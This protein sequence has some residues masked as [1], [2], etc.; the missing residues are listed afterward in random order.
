M[1]GAVVDATPTRAGMNSYTETGKIGGLTGVRIDDPID[2]QVDGFLVE[3]PF[4]LNERG[5]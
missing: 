2:V 3:S 1:N 5:Q 4:R